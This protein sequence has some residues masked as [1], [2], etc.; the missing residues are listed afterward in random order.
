[1]QRTPPMAHRSTALQ[2][3]NRFP[4]RWLPFL[5]ATTASCALDDG[6]GTATPADTR[7]DTGNLDAGNT[8]SDKGPPLTETHS[9]WK[10][11]ACMG[12]HD[13]SAAPYPHDEDGLTPPD[14]GACH[15]YNGAPHSDHA[16]LDNPG[17]DECHNRNTVSH[18]DNFVFPDNC[19]KCHYHS[20]SLEGL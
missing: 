7:G 16:S 4:L 6:A 18:F 5:L 9:G 12:C 1:M 20:E 3:R 13:G 11:P 10:Q 15:G 2:R 17:C 14:C 8:S 19:V